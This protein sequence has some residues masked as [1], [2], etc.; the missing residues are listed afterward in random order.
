MCVHYT[1][2]C[3]YLPT[4]YANHRIYF[5]YTVKHLFT[6]LFEQF[7]YYYKICI[8]LFSYKCA[9]FK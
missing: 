8:K 5:Y 6:L 9:A 7:F 3:T 4:V 1:F 2:M